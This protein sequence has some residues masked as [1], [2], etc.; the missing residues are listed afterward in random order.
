MLQFW[1]GEL[2]VTMV[3]SSPNIQEVSEL[4]GKA[5]DVHKTDHGFRISKL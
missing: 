3:N 2:R 5:L 1:V 4:C